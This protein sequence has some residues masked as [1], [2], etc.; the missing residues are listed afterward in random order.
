LDRGRPPPEASPPRVSMGRE[1]ARFFGFGVRGAGLVMRR[2]H[3]GGVKRGGV[4][5]RAE[6][7]DGG[8]LQ[9]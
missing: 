5:G 8:G 3:P 4:C 9:Y 7:G 2:G 6:T 1:A